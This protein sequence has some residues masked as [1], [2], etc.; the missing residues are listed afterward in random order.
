MHSHSHAVVLKPRPIS[1]R[2]TEWG[3]NPWS[4][5]AQECQSRVLTRPDGFAEN[6]YDFGGACS[7]W[8]PLFF[9]ICA[10]K[11]KKTFHIPLMWDK[12]GKRIVICRYARSKD[13]RLES[14]MFK[15]VKGLRLGAFWHN[16]MEGIGDLKE[17]S[18]N[19]LKSRSSTT[20]WENTW[21][22]YLQWVAELL[23]WLLVSQIYPVPLIRK[24][25]FSWV[26]H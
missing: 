4:S 5:A 11:K 14:R 13:F 12:E 19:C 3:N 17:S 6:G 2:L 20:S 9:L 25:I 26:D 23:R 1:N 7:L 10:M 24:G 15:L 18:T 21:Q 8:F 16:L 22:I